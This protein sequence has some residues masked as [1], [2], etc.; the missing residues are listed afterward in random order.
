[1]VIGAN[2]GS[3]RCRGLPMPTMTLNSNGRARKTL[4]EQ[5]D[6]LDAILDGLAEALHQ[7][8]AQA[9]QEAV[10]LAVKAALA[11]A[12]AHPEL[13]QALQARPAPA[14]RSEEHTSELQSR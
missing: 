9:V 10:G 11:E 13:R 1:T 12:L 5:I 6:R 7:S 14:P 2:G 4:A 8:V 3:I